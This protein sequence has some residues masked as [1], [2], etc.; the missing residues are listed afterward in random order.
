M[1]IVITG[2]AGFIGSH[3]AEKLIEAGHEVV[4]ID[5]LSTGSQTNLTGLKG[6]PAFEFI[7]DDVRNRHTLHILIEQCDVVFHLAAAVG[8][9]L[10]GEK[11]AHMIETNIDGTRIVLDV[12]GKSGKKVLVASSSEIYGKSNVV[13]F[14]EDD[15][16]LLGNTRSFRWSYACS[17][18]TAEFLGLA[19]HREHGSPVII[20][21]LFNT[22][23]PRQSGRYGMV[24]PRFV[25]QALKDEPITI[26][27]TGQQTRCFAYVGD[28]V[29]GLIGLM[30]CPQAV[31]R[32][33]NLG[34]TEETT[35]ES[36]AD[37]II[38][39]TASKSKKQ[40]I[41]Y[42]EAYG[43]GFEDIIRRVPCLERIEKCIGYR[44]KTSLEQSL[45]MVID[46]F[47]D[48]L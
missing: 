5:D 22:I 46:D 4:G 44:P 2:A 31:G 18:L 20:A 38:E 13:P 30:D 26:Y 32:V 37:K 43:Q 27:G 29:D 45:Q 11:P 12:A 3:L 36:L 28:V 19:Y 24:V 23:G 48:R 7:E 39:M 33:Y 47:K 9:Q 25:S 10:I 41:S 16:I 14:R 17:K 42:Q 40:F 1:N 15:D 21:R 6:D 35:I 34:S 8:V